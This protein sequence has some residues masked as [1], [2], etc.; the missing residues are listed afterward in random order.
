M[1]T[2]FAPG[3]RCSRLLLILGTFVFAGASVLQTLPEA[4]CWGQDDEP[5]Y[6][7]TATEARSQIGAT[8]FVT[9]R[10]D[11]EKPNRPLFVKHFPPEAG[12]KIKA[13]PGEYIQDEKTA[14]SIT[15]LDQQVKVAASADG[16]YAGF[17]GSAKAAFEGTSRTS[18]EVHYGGFVTENVRAIYDLETGSNASLLT[19]IFQ[20]VREHIQKEVPNAPLSRANAKK[21]EEFFSK[22]GSHLCVSVTYGAYA[23]SYFQASKKN[24]VSTKTL[25]AMAKGSY[26]GAGSANVEA[27]LDAAQKLEKQDASFKKFAVVAG[28]TAGGAAQVLKDPKEVGVW[29][30]SLNF[31]DGNLALMDQKFV[32]IW[33]VFKN[34]ND[35]LR[36]NLK[37]A[38][39]ILYDDNTGV[40]YGDPV[41]LLCEMGNDKD[42]SY[43]GG[44]FGGTSR[45]QTHVPTETA[46]Y[47]NK[48][49][50]P[51]FLWKFVS[52]G[53][54]SMKGPVFTD[55]R[56]FLTNVAA[57]QRL[58]V[59][60]GGE[61]GDLWWAYPGDPGRIKESY[62]TWMVEPIEKSKFN[63]AAL[64]TP[65]R[66]RF[67]L[68]DQSGNKAWGHFR[69][70]GHRG[71]ELNPGQKHVEAVFQD[72]DK[73]QGL[74]H[75]KWTVTRD[76]GFK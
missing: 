48:N 35:E 26:K 22:Y 38:W 42:G 52:S 29:L 12:M 6:E 3:R 40:H 5:N 28:G 70:A 25:S 63:S 64:I 57:N 24:S 27:S 66:T 45:C 33:M 71:G 44:G 21:Y 11:G 23:R 49:Y 31:Q 9:S 50:H 53:D 74:Q 59:R 62:S 36:K 67:Y 19:S 14:D 34:V 37:D 73:E 75:F 30:E 4:Q 17:S 68:P 32:G 69:L 65:F 54:E 41:Y 51:R 56:F 60:N 15:E 47:R 2:H 8:Y 72:R 55:D 10:Y 1:S 16:E 20:Q 43:L 58:Y 13:R 46:I 39:S 61:A 18:E 7:K 76:K